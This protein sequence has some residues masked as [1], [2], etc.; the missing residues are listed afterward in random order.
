MV[1]SSGRGRPGPAGP[2]TLLFPASRTRVSP[3]GQAA[4]TSPR[5]SFVSQITSYYLFPSPRP[6]G[7]KRLLPVAQSAS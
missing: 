1:S 5:F 7:A 3:L 6:L 4:V 2:Q